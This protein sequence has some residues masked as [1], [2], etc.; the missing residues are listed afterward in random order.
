MHCRIMVVFVIWSYDF[1]SRCGHLFMFSKVSFEFEF[2]LVK[3][4]SPF[5]SK[6]FCM[7]NLA[8]R[9]LCG[10]VVMVIAGNQFRQTVFDSYCRVL[11]CT[12]WHIKMTAA[13]FEPTP[14]RNGALSHRCR[15]LGQTVLIAGSGRDAGGQMH[16]EQ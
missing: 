16:K 11:I 14:F 4:W 13:G 6:Y 7:S 3:A 5:I 9:I 1:F 2:R 8:R 12:P 15:P 10:G